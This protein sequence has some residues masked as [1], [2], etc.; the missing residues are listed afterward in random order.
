MNKPRG[1]EGYKRSH[2]KYLY[3]ME[4]KDYIKIGISF[5]PNHRCYNL[6]YDLE[7]K[8]NQFKIVKYI[9][10]LD[11][12][13]AR[14][15]E[16][17]LHLIFKDKQIITDFLGAKTECFCRSIKDDVL[18]KL[19]ELDKYRYYD[20]FLSCHPKHY[21][22]FL[23]LNNITVEDICS[24]VGKS[25]TKYA[26]QAVQLSLCNILANIQTSQDKLLVY[27]RNEVDNL[28]SGGVI[29]TRILR[30]LF[31]SDGVININNFNI[32]EDID[33]RYDVR[34]GCRLKN[35]HFTQG[36]SPLY[37]KELYSYVNNISEYLTRMINTKSTLAIY[38]EIL[39]DK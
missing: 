16:K 14:T 13:T 31:L 8:N 11:G 27:G 32:P 6:N 7:D 24:L 9:D 33:I 5:D 20:P 23:E 38:R 19:D 34:V 26:K 3:V 1:Y 22:A 37:L 28:T 17:H 2:S 18:S 39:I 12:L 35:R 15:L 30:E 25:P 36:V 10:C 29:C 4:N 21:R